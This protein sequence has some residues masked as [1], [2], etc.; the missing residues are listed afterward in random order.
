[1]RRIEWKV[2]GK[3]RQVRPDALLQKKPEFHVR[4]A[5]IRAPEL[6]PESLAN[7]SAAKGQGLADNQTFTKWR[8]GG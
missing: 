1:M 7:C 4:M 2:N 3:K 6:D 8:N 5:D